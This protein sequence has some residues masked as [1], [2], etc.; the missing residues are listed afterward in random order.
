MPLASRLW[1]SWAW[2][3]SD[4]RRVFRTSSGAVTAAAVMPPIL[5]RSLLEN[6][7][8][9]ERVGKEAHPPATKW[10]HDLATGEVLWA[11]EGAWSVCGGPSSPSSRD[12]MR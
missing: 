5:Q 8:V 10:A 11:I 9:P 12:W 3:K 4:C 6:V 2:E 1:A 7:S